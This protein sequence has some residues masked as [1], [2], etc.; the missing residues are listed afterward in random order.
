MGR[1]T[2]R[3]TGRGEYWADVIR[4][5]Q[6]QKKDVL[7]KKPKMIGFRCGILNSLYLW[8]GHESCASAVRALEDSQK[9][10]RLSSDCG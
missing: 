1:R 4:A 8:G 10:N 9:Q 5:S 7:V 2:R 6:V 3:R